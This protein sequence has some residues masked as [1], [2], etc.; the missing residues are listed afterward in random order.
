MEV[1]FAV[2]VTWEALERS[3]AGPSLLCVSVEKAKVVGVSGLDSLPSHLGET[4]RF[5]HPHL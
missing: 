2:A 3:P 5:H 1:G 4:Q